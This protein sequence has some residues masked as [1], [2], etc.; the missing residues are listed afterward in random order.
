MANTWVGFVSNW[1]FQNDI[2]WNSGKVGFY[3][4]SHICELIWENHQ[5]YH[6]IA[7]NFKY[8][9]HH[10]SLM[11]DYSNARF[12]R[13]TRVVF[14]LVFYSYIANTAGFWTTFFT[15]A[16]MS[17]IVSIRW[18]AGGREVRWVGGQLETSYTF[19]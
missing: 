8:W 3:S 9:N 11:L 7:T 1:I 13:I 12:T 10:G 18:W 16:V 14:W 5:N 19:Q 4:Y 2:S 15:T 17:W 6:I